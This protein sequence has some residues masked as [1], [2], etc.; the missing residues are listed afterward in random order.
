MNRK[1][2]G[3]FALVLMLP[4]A[5]C[6]DGTTVG[7]PGT[8]SLM[9]TDDEGDFTQ[10][11]V[12][13]ERI[14]LAGD[15]SDGDPV[16]LL[17]TPF[18]TDLLTLSNDVVGLVEDET[19]PAGTYAQLRFVISDACIGVEQ[20]DESEM[21]YASSGFDECGEPDGNLQ[22]PSF[23]SSGLKVSLP[24]GAIEVDGDA[25]ILL[26]DFDVAESFGRQAGMSGMWVMHPLIR[27][28]DLSLN[29]SI[30]V[31]LTVAE[32][33]DLSTVSS[34][35]ADFQAM[36]DT[37]TE[38]LAFTDPDDDGVFTAI[39]LYLLPDQD[40]EVSVGLQDGISYDFTLDPTSPQSV[41]LGNADQ[42][43][44]SFEVTSA[45]PSS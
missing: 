7:S 28:D 17:D 11:R 45:A 9:L 38:P 3:M 37:E 23:G 31:E 26:L 44:V 1:T 8:M 2:I 27:A 15:D 14:E 19:V 35:L 33:V 41:S 39:F 40:Y 12:V 5:A 29:G 22:L 20:A 10:A 4:L 36:L 16:V 13:I 6:D 30:A 21:I 24:G 18:S 34:S 32:G 25:H 42:V 43:T